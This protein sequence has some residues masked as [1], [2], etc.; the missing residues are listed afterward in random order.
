MIKSFYF[1]L[2]LTL[3]SAC[4]HLNDQVNDVSTPESASVSQEIPDPT[5]EVSSESE[6][7]LDYF[8]LVKRDIHRLNP[9]L[10]ECYRNNIDLKNRSP[11][12]KF[13]LELGVLSDGTISLAEDMERELRQSVG[14]SPASD[15]TSMQQCLRDQFQYLRF[16]SYDE[17]IDLHIEIKY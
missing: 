2:S 4:A 9:K 17:E 5:V 3:L 11:H 1:V 10:V 13:E 16:P 8:N 14:R 15:R 6:A 7:T 12:R